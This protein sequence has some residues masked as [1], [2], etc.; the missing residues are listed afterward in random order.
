MVVFVFC[1]DD[2]KI[3]LQCTKK[4]RGSTI[5]RES[6]KDETVRRLLFEATYLP[7]RRALNLFIQPACPGSPGLSFFSAASEKEK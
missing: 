3:T 1:D 6:S 5:E 7:R 4:I 2:K